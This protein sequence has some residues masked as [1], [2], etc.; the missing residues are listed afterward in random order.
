MLPA[1]TIRP[2]TEMLITN[3]NRKSSGA[4][5]S[6]ETSLEDKQASPKFKFDG[7]ASGARIDHLLYANGLVPFIH[8]PIV[9]PPKPE[10]QK[11]KGRGRKGPAQPSAATTSWERGEKI[12]EAGGKAKKAK[13]G[14]GMANTHAQASSCV[15]T[16]E[17]IVSA[18]LELGSGR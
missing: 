17:S 13:L 9:P 12:N 5:T 1:K 2:P 10:V 18:L 16:N 4:I 11:L 8:L 14:S 6:D 15:N 3:N 7:K